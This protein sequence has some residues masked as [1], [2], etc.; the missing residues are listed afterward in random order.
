V[1][2]PALH[3]APR[4][5]QAAH[6]RW[7]GGGRAALA[8]VLLIITCEISSFQAKFPVLNGC[9][10]MTNSIAATKS[11]C[12]LLGAFECLLLDLETLVRLSV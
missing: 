1:Q 11:D 10:A 8:L 6:L 5:L 2:L 12:H 9:L 4:H 7:L 3:K